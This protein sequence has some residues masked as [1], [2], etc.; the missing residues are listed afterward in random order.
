MA[1]RKE[2]TEVRAGKGRKPEKRVEEEILS[3][4][5]FPA[6]NPN[7]IIR[8]SK[9]GKILYGNPASAPLLSQWKCQVGELASEEWRQRVADAYSSSLKKELED[10]IG[11]RT[12][13]FTLAPIKG[14]GY[15]N[16]YGR[17]VTERKKAEDEI[18][19]AKNEWERTF[20]SVPDLIAILDNEHR[21]VRAN[22]SMAQRLGV[23]PDQ[24]VGLNCFRCVHKLDAPPSFCPHSL[25]LADGK[26][27]VAEVH[28]DNLGGDFLVS[29]TPLFDQQ[30]QMIGS[31]HVARDITQRKKMEEALRESEERYRQIIE[32]TEEGVW[33]SMPD[34]RAT[35]VN[36]R[37]ADM[38]GY[39]REEI[40]GKAGLDFLVEGQEQTVVQ[41]REGLEEGERIQREYQF[42]HKDGTTLWTLASAS[43][44]LDKNGQHIA[45]LA[46]HTDITA[47]KKA[48]EALRKAHDQLEMRV[49][50]RTKE[51][52]EASEKLLVE[53]A[54]RKRAEEAVKA[55]RKRFI[56]VLEQLPAY[57][58][59]LTPDYHVSYANRYFREHFGEDR[60][61]HCFEYLFGRTEPCETCE[62]YKTLKKMSPLEWEWTGPDGHNYYIYD[63]PFT[64]ADG[65][66][67]ILE[68]GIDITE[69]KKAEEA[70]RKAHD[71]LEI[72]VQERTKEIRQ[73]NWEL[74]TE[75]TERKKTEEALRK[76]QTLLQEAERLSHTGAWEWDVSSNQWT[77]SDEWLTIHGCQK[78]SL[79]SEE[80][81]PIAHPDD[82]PRIERT[83]E[84]ARSGIK[85]YDIE[86]RI[87]RQDTGEVR[88]VKAYGT[89]VR[90][91]QGLPLRMLGV[92]QDVTE[93][94]NTEEA[95]R[96]SAET[97][98]QHAEELEKIMDVAPNA[99]WVSRDPECRV[100]TGNRAANQFY[101]AAPGEN[102][103]A[104]PATGGEQD[105][106]RRFFQNGRELKPEELPM[107]EAAAKGVEI[108]DSE[109][110]VLLPSGRTITILGS[111]SPLKDAAGKVRGCIASFMNITERKRAEQALKDSQNDLN[112]AQ[113]VARTGSWR[114]NVQRNELLWS[115]ET[116]RIFG[117]PK[118]TS[119]TYESF[120]A[121]VHP[122][123]RDYVNQKW[124]A[125]LKGEPYDIEHRIVSDGKVKWVREKAELEIDEHGSLLGG[126]GTVQDM[127][128]RKQIENALRETR[129]YL[130]NLLNYASAP[131]IVWD[132]EFRITRF[133]RA[134]EHLSA[135]KAEEVAGKDLSMLFPKES[136]EESLKEIQH[137]L[138]GEYWESMEIPILRKDGDART[139]LW[140]SANIYAQDGK[141]LMATIAQ[142]I[143]ITERKKL[144]EKLKKA[145]RMAAIG[146]TAAMVGH[147]LRNP[148][149][150]TV[151]FIGLAEEQL[152][153]I[154]RSSEEKQK[155]EEPLKAIKKQA[156]YMN[157]IV[158]DLQD[159]ARP[160]KPELKETDLTNIINEVISSLQIPQTIET[161]ISIPQDFAKVSVDPT[162]ITRALTNLLRN[163]VE[164]MP[165]GGKL[166]M[167]ASQD[168]EGVYIKIIDTGIGI[169]EEDMPK[170]FTP[171]FTTKAKGQG[172]GLPVSK[173]IM[174]A[175]GGSIK[176][177]SQLGKGSTF[178]LKIPLD[179]RNQ[180]KNT[181]KT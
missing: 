124:Q 89:L 151:G 48:E 146:E 18:L 83:L 65:S 19:R 104:G 174:E 4:S 158:L 152:Q 133:N 126:F 119:M 76:N 47:R 95:L 28:E 79:S 111:A 163:A 55:E 34:G 90:D 100:I 178:T 105:T 155:I 30:G 115:D 166:T 49:E 41:T 37:M 132:S 92:A 175:H 137:T 69:R 156:Q 13:Q 142:G 129:D 98:R 134:F 121:A 135:Y 35:F 53:N 11:D 45:N 114:L 177:E 82:R 62:T 97:A 172:F 50:E 140:N 138:A 165:E 148:L 96:R 118:G 22:K 106:A 120:L 154:G 46:M 59:L 160:L 87:I 8:M 157:K 21:I 33:M 80:L 39:A 139:V 78:N 94:R 67:L 93:S 85:P 159:Y 145:E 27:H 103:S 180:K 74:Q 112:R 86:H 168:H 167:E 10:E 110:D 2:K 26:E 181:H 81:L 91:A 20:E 17:D 51:L 107:Q 32:T 150:A 162:L 5:R 66:T 101:E 170:L 31:V 6:E 1:R 23:T 117:I 149:Q 57:L 77:F 42:R 147:D 113:A 161:S 127:T 153:N 38:L 108:R 72:R 171:L 36:Q 25:T 3:L 52:R 54:E 131:I 12:F 40:I 56:D 164:A 102:V 179:K 24:C 71:E 169:A 70:L 44:I 14:A 58:V 125:A 128:E 73:T 61:R 15:V 43:P 68:V 99:L 84:D 141:T 116:Y 16:I 130:E 64:D 123:D 143:D 109:V 60:G 88:I 7:P 176:V 63:A 29:T 9:D 122:D 75:I 173:Q 136:R 144:E